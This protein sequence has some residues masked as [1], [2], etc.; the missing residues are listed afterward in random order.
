MTPDPRLERG[1]HVAAALPALISRS[2]TSAPG[3][4]A[5]PS[6]QGR[7]QQDDG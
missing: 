3:K 7:E 5:A 6:D 4:A 1:F 2:G